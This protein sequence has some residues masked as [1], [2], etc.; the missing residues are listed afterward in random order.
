MDN[1]SLMILKSVKYDVQQDDHLTGGIFRIIQANQWI[2][3]NYERLCNNQMIECDV[4]P[5]FYVFVL[6]PQL[7]SHRKRYKKL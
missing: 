6:I 1:V 4:S 7:S 3:E 5:E 2:M